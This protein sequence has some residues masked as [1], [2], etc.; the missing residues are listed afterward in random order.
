MPNKRKKRAAKPKVE[1][2]EEGVKVTYP[3]RVLPPTLTPLRK[4]RHCPSCGWGPASR[5]DRYG[6]TKS[7]YLYECQ[8]CVDEDRCL[9]TRWQEP[10]G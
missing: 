6:S 2:T 1:E 5:V 10:R 8:K 3:E 7:A 9:P 4:K